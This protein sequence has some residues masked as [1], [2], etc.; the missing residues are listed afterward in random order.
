MPRT[1]FRPR[2]HGFHFANN[3]VNQ[4][5]PL[6]DGQSVTTAGRCGGM[7]YAALDYYHAN[8]P[9][10]IHRPADFPGD[11]PEDGSTLGDYIY[12]R[13]FDSFAQWSAHKYVAWTV[14]PDEQTWYSNGVTR[15]TREEEFPKLKQAIDAG[16][17][18][19]LGLIRAREL[20]NIGG[21]H[22]VVAYGYDQTGSGFEVY[23]YDNNAPNREITI[24][25][26]EGL[27]YV[28]QRPDGTTSNWRGFFVHDYQPRT[29][30]YAD[31]V[32][33]GISVSTPE[34][35]LGSPLL[36]SLT[37]H[38]VGDYSVRP[39]S[40]EP[41]VLGP[42][43]Q[44]YESFF[45]AEPVAGPIAPGDA[46]WVQVEAPEFGA[47]TGR[48]EI[49]GRFTTDQGEAFTLPA[50]DANTMNCYVVNVGRSA[51]D[52]V[53]LDREGR[54]VTSPPYTV[55][56]SGP[57]GGERSFPIRLRNDGTRPVEITGVRP[58]RAGGRLTVRWPNDLA[59][60]AGGTGAVR[61]RMGEWRRN[62][63]ITI[64]P[65][66]DRWVDPGEVVE[67]TGW[68]T[69]GGEGA[70]TG[71]LTVESSGRTTQQL[72]IDVVGRGYH[73][74]RVVQPRRPIEL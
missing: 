34:P 50:T 15:M 32:Y 54:A 13:L 27:G 8:R 42:N 4:V 29:P 63:P 10:P 3:F 19:V 12:G 31:L 41:I 70:V 62:Q 47:R 55:R 22:Q 16:R 67:L 57:V 40:L 56:V 18:V 69:P 74:R 11:V 6:P 51:P 46:R 30:P 66:D 60:D 1:D 53:L 71:R 64:E 35:A 48:H 26:A 43:G 58:A 44:L 17:P 68:F 59:F 49:Y 24:R 38:N 23:V 21:H 7:A 14:L 5:M 36:V 73:D 37:V 28:A 9:V 45:E 65:P 20:E 72:P 33:G 39:T 52:L 2:R 25:P 61:E